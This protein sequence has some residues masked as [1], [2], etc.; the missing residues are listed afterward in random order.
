LGFGLNTLPEVPGINHIE[1]Q[2]PINGLSLA[3]RADFLILCCIPVGAIE[4]Y[5]FGFICGEIRS[6]RTSH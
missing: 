4:N 5:Y 1:N 2:S 6:R 3:K